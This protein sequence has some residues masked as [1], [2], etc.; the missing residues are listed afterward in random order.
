[1]S[2]GQLP[3]IFA[4]GALAF[5]LRRFGAKA[6]LLA[7]VALGIFRFGACAFGSG[8]ALIYTALS[9]HGLVYTFT[10][11]T[12]VI[13]LERFCGPRDRTGV[14]QLF[15]VLTGG[16][17]GF[18][19]SYAAGR[20]LDAFTGEAGLVDYSAFWTVPFALSV[21]LFVA[22]LFVRMPGTGRGADTY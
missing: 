14:H 5:L 7:G 2:L 4:M 3:E 22:I 15:A 12:V 17:G 13:C 1:M 9:V 18:L 20:A 6:V 10:M 21:A 16:V 19:G 8:A 11:I